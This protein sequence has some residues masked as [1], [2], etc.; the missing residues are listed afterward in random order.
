MSHTPGPWKLL[1]QKAG[2][3]WK[4]E[5]YS[6]IPATDELGDHAD[7]IAHIFW[8]SG[9][10]PQDHANAA[11]V[12]TACNAHDE[13]VEAVKKSRRTLAVAIRAASEG[14]MTDEDISEH[15]VIKILDAALSKA[16][17]GL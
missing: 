10:R 8:H 12:I 2:G 13:L 6:I 17:G 9:I 16:G 11:F 15:S 1:H 5:L 14:R 4:P 7:A 3:N